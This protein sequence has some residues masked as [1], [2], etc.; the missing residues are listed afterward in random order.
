[1]LSRARSIICCA[2]A[3]MAED[4]F[5]FVIGLAVPG[6]R[7]S[8]GGARSGSELSHLFRS[9]VSIF[10]IDSAAP[11]SHRYTGLYIIQRMCLFDGRTA[12]TG[13]RSLGAGHCSY[14]VYWNAPVAWVML[15]RV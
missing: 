5:G 12:I 15:Q 4:V 9:L 7:G 13:W 8:G 1:M 14:C 10:M 2:A 3:A 6:L 11:D